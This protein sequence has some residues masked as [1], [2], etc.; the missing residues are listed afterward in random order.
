MARG[1]KA[2]TALPDCEFL[3]NYHV[4]LMMNSSSVVELSDDGK[5]VR[6]NI[7]EALH[8]HSGGWIQK[9]SLAYHVKSETH[10]RSV[11]AKQNEELRQTV[12]E[13]SMEEERAMEQRMDFV[14]LSSTAKPTV[15][16][17]VRVHVTSTEEQDMWDQHTLFN[18]AFDAGI[19]HI[20]A[21]V[22]ERKRLEREATNFDLWHGA[23]FAP[24]VPHDGELLLD[25]LEQD[26]ILT[27][28]LRNTRL[29][30]PISSELST[31]FN[32]FGQIWILQMYLQKRRGVI[33]VSPRLSMPGHRTSPR[34]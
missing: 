10:A 34:W 26:D 17:T 7:C 18:E 21:A 25:E 3:S 12:G 4:V 28:L 8:G 19:D 27:E 16:Q 30:Y 9:E 11:S 20:A 33:Q 23:D 2:K 14:M 29:Y 13:Q 6:C 22:D 5:K 15:T 32:I 31:Q 1:R 24:E